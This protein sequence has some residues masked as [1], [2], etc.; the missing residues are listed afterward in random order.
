MNVLQFP[1]RDFVCVGI[2]KR[3]PFEQG[4]FSKISFSS[5]ELRDSR[6]SRDPPECKTKGK[7]NMF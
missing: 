7:P 2:R 1:G 5:R 3:G 6:D 4:V